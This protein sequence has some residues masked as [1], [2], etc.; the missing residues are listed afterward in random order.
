MNMRNLFVKAATNHEVYEAILCT[1]RKTSTALDRMM[2]AGFEF[3]GSNNVV[4]LSKLDSDDIQKLDSAVKGILYLHSISP[5][6]TGRKEAG[7]VKEKAKM[8]ADFNIMLNEAIAIA[9]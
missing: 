3:D 4:R 2:R 1:M 5:L 8:I 6:W 7:S 9:M